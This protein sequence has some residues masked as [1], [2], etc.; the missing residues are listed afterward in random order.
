VEVV[1]NSIN[2]RLGC[3]SRLDVVASTMNS[4]TLSSVEHDVM[5]A[6][7]AVDCNVQ[8][9]LSGPTRIVRLVAAVPRIRRAAVVLPLLGSSLS[10]ECCETKKEVN[11]GS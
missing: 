11:T 5:D 9:N 1:N 7:D 3:M 6:V 2:K 4:G 8:F 10:R